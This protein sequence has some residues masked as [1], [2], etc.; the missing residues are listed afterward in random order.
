MAKMFYS[1]E[2]A[3]SKLGVSADAVKEMASSGKLAE[4]RDRDRLMFKVEQVDLLA[5]A[6][7]RKKGESGG[8][9]LADSA[10][11]EPLSLASS[12]SSPGLADTP[13]TGSANV[14]EQTG[15]SI[16]DADQTEEAD[17]SAVTRVTQSPAAAESASG[18]SGM[19]Q[20]SGL[21]ADLLEDAYGSRAGQ[22]GVTS[23]EGGG[24]FET[25]AAEVEPVAPAMVAM[26]AEPYDGAGSGLVGGLAIGA[27]VSLL[28]ATAAIVLG[29]SGAAGSGLLSDLGQNM[30][31]IVGACAG[32]TVVGAILGYVLGK[33][34]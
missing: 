4:F 22:Q 10:E 11:L 13:A 20:D 30:M 34:S 17:P 33:R 31:V 21:G 16:F 14:K 19:L 25:G 8:Y 1:I 15:I 24:L 28:V 3:A 12:G 18:G 7:G 29:L 2:E 6:T 9:G 27:L 26:V 5:S 23:T 32:V